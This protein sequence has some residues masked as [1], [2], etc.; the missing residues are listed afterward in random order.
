M[1]SGI[2]GVVKGCQMMLRAE[3]EISG[4]IGAESEDEVRQ[5][6]SLLTCLAEI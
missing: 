3:S 1:S 4:G 5:R 6:T 2:G